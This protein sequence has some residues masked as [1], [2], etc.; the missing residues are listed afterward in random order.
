MTRF[1]K[2]SDFCP[3]PKMCSG[4]VPTVTL[5]GFVQVAGKRPEELVVPDGVQAK[6]EGSAKKKL[7]SPGSGVFACYST[8]AYVKLCFIIL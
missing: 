5:Q 2:S 3:L 7:K 6:V 4:S 8:P 1:W